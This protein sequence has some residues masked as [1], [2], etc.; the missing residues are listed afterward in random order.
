EENKQKAKTKT[1]FSNT[2]IRSLQKNI[3]NLHLLVD[4][5]RALYKGRK[6]KKKVQL[7]APLRYYCL[8]LP[9]EL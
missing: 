9:F 6:A 5:T 4:S 3:I 8:T 2:K 1:Q 7:L